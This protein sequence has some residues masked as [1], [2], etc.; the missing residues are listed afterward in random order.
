MSL[1][2]NPLPGESVIRQAIAGRGGATL[3]L[4]CLVGATPTGGSAQELVP[5]AYT[6]APT[7]VNLVTLALGHN[8]GDVS[9][10]PSL[11]V[12]E[13]SA[14]I[15]AASFG[16]ARTFGLLGR[17]ANITVV[18]P[19]LVGDLDGLYFGEQTSVERSG[20]ADLAVR[21]GINLLGAPAMDAMAFRTY[22]P[23]TLLG[24]SLLV[25]APTGEYDSTKLINIGTNRWGF[26]PEIGVV[27]MVG[28]WSFDA[29]LGGW[30][31]TDN[32]DFYGGRTRIQGPILSTEAHVRYSVSGTLWASLDGNFWRGGRTT[33]EGVPSEDWQ[34]NSRIGLTLAWQVARQHG[35]RF[36]ASRGAITR[37][38]GDFASV[39]V[40][41]SYNWMK[42]A[43]AR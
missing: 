5:A 8:S 20:L 38:G 3:L 39:G 22:R 37:I 7:G 23:G 29:Y 12:E 24:A 17:A 43:T 31:F 25:R 21:F 35:L 34:R 9:F 14:R 15:N 16:Y 13:A 27:H 40:S 28:R 10:D 19:Y 6:P 42:R 4:L 33:V 1:H 18:A 30:F 36:A 26:K 41:Y 32:T 11:P 2:L